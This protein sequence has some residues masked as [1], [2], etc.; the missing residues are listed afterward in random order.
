MNLSVL[1]KK[2]IS[3]CP[4]FQIYISKPCICELLNHQRTQNDVFKNS[5]KNLMPHADKNNIKRQKK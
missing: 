5:N 2:Q 3:C 4:I 1:P